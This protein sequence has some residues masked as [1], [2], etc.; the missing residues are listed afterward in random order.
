ME[1]PTNN[2]NILLPKINNKSEDIPN[3]STATSAGLSKPADD[4]NKNESEKTKFAKSYKYDK[5]SGRS[6][7]R[8]PFISEDTEDEKDEHTGLHFQRGVDAFKHLNKVP[9]SARKL[10]EEHIRKLEDRAW[11]DDLEAFL[12]SREKERAARILAALSQREK[13]ACNIGELSPER[14]LKIKRVEHPS[15]GA[16]TYTAFY[17]KKSDCPE[18]EFVMNLRDTSPSRP[19]GKRET[20]FN[21][22]MDSLSDDLAR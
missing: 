16:S 2:G 5:P 13:L 17:R 10:F 1:K 20:Q 14:P 21:L 6:L 19:S 15:P 12:I 7:N 11:E 3:Q 22:R 8:P 18:P 4:K 9:V